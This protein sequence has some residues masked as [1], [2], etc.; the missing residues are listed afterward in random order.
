LGQRIHARQNGRPYS[1]GCSAREE[2]SPAESFFFLELWV[3][4]AGAALLGHVFLPE[5]D[6]GTRCDWSMTKE[7]PLQQV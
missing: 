6:A 1:G 7:L 3:F 4:P 2:I 5:S